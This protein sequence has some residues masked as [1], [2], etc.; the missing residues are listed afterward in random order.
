MTGSG[1][2]SW[3]DDGKEMRRMEIK[4]GDVYRLYA[5]SVFFVQSNLETER[6]N[7]RIYSIYSNTDEDIYVGAYS[8][9]SDLVLGFD[10]KLLKSAFNAGDDVVEEMVNASRP[11][12]IVH[13]MPEEEKKK[14]IFKEIEARI[15]KA[16]IGNTDSP[17]YDFSNGKKKS[18][19]FNIL[20]ANP[21]FENCNGWSVTVDR[22]DLKSLRHTNIGIF[23]VNLTKGS[24]MGPHWNPLAT[25]IAIVV[26]GEGMIKVVCGSNANE[27]ECKNMRFRVKE[28]DVF[29]V[30]RFH[31]MAQMSFNNDTFVFMGFSTSTRRNYPQFLAGKS[32]V[33]QTLSRDILALSFNVTNTTIDALL[34]PQEEAIILDCTSCAEEEELKMVKEWEEE[35]ARERGEERKREKEKRRR[36]RRRE[37][38]GGRKE[39]ERRGEKEGGRGGC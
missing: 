9:I 5:G 4:R 35:K 17:F 14:S 32:S 1:K 31:P 28:G 15:V 27:T 23:M 36:R 22:K 8:S 33:L 30:P 3:S 10:R 11:E 19:T 39:G 38:E 34:T 20:E 13:A 16:V 29:T 21:D 2:L 6:Q 12:A 24:M 18:K 25:E 26:Q 7:L 37:E